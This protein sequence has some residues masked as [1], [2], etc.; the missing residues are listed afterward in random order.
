MKVLLSFLF[1]C[2][3]SAQLLSPRDSSL[4]PNKIMG[5]SALAAPEKPSATVLWN[6][7]VSK[8]VVSYKL[9]QGGASKVYTNNITTQLLNVV[10]TNLIAGA[11]YYFAATAVHV[12]GAESPFSEEIS[13]QVPADAN[14]LTVR[15]TTLSK[16][17]SIV[18]QTESSQVPPIT[19]TVP[20][21]DP[22]RYSG[23]KVEIIKQ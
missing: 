5:E 10:V 15:V 22:K 12:L 18:T 19:F 13:Y 6:P 7:S 2:S 14:M 17:G 1:V 16:T 8:D 20:P 11:T 3:A 23:T 9:Y 4:M 21:R